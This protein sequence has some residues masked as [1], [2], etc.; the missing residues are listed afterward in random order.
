MVLLAAVSGSAEIK[1]SEADAKRAALVKPTPTISATARQLKLS[2]RVELAV[3]IDEEGNV[4][5]VRVAI[6]SPVLGAGAVD[7]VKHWKFKPFTDNGKS[8]KAE[9]TLAFEFKQ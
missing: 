1:V 7:A 4:T 9:A 5:N 6:G 8:T 3:N 2:G